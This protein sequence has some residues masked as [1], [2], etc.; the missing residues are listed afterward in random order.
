MLLFNLFFFTDAH[1]HNDKEIDIDIVLSKLNSCYNEPAF[2]TSV[3]FVAH[4]VE[5]ND[6]LLDREDVISHFLNG[7]C[8]NK[9]ASGCLEVAQTVKSPIKIALNVT[10]AIIVECEHKH[11][12]L[13]NLRAYCS[14]IG[15]VTTQRP[16][17]YPLVQRLRSRCNALRPLLDCN[18]LETM[19]CVETLGKQSMQHLSTQ[20][21][22]SV[23][24]EHNVDSMKTAVVDH[25]SA[26][27]CQA[28]TSSLCKSINDEY[29]NSEA[30]P[31]SDLETYIL[32]LAAKKAKL[33]KKGLRRVL[34]SRNIEFDGNDNN[35]DLRR[36]LRSYITKLRKGKQS[37]WS[38]NQRT[39][40]EDEYQ[41]RLDEIREE[42]PHSVPMDLKE[43]CLRHFRTAT[44]SESLREFTCAC[45][46]ESVNL[47]NCRVRQLT[48]FNL[49]I[50]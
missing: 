26:G 17:Y 6:I 41:H 47:S 48:E 35:G 24:P 18:G 28:S 20:H 19:F 10:E 12:H 32:Q 5:S 50:M 27:G 13:N 11:I 40:I 49:E 23:D 38:R 14:A 37:E 25:I 21:N 33:S 42:W 30:G 22:V 43:N 34:K 31:M 45:C 8:A 16:E 46:A 39:E 4:G 9:Q 7:Q 3:F 2:D 29:Q 1:E 36:H 44:S 15:I